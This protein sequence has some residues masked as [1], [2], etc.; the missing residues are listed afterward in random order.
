MALIK[1]FLSLKVYHI[2]ILQAKWNAKITRYSIIP[3]SCT[4]ETKKTLKCS[5]SF[6]A[7]NLLEEASD[8]RWA[9]KYCWYRL[10]LRNTMGSNCAA[11]P[12]QYTVQSG[13]SKSVLNTAVT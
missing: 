2:F 10:G 9:Q 6:K 12:R 11:Q 7:S 13:V 1:W 5:F 4:T 3:V 8:H